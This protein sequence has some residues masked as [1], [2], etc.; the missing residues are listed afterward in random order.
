ML[1]LR[2][3]ALAL[4]RVRFQPERFSEVWERQDGI[5]KTGASGGQKFHELLG[6]GYMF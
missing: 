5:L 6:A 1:F 3:T 2:R 4:R